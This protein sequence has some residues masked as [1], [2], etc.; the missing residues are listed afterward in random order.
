M[1]LERGTLLREGTGLTGQE[2]NI[3][4]WPCLTCIAAVGFSGLYLHV[5]SEERMLTQSSGGRS[6]QAHTRE[7]SWSIP[8]SNLSLS[9]AHHVT[10]ASPVASPKTHSL[11]IPKRNR[12]TSPRGCRQHHFCKAQFQ[13]P[14]PGSVQWLCHG[15][16]YKSN[17]YSYFIYYI[18]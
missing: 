18:T 13:A 11:S 1:D 5:S 14:L 7:Y 10:R 15:R 3:L 2:R 9:P 6:A 8:G 12:D 4:N 16:Y 17:H